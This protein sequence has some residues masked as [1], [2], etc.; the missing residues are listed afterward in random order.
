MRTLELTTLF[1]SIS[2]VENSTFFEMEQL[3][4]QYPNDF[5]FGRYRQEV[6]HYD[7]KLYAFGGGKIDGDAYGFDSVIKSKILT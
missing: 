6:T 3:A 2:L 1:D 5:L 7:G 4:E